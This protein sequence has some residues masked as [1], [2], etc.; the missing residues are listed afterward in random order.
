MTVSSRVCL[1]V[2]GDASCRFAG[3]RR[4]KVDSRQD[5]CPLIAGRSNTWTC[6]STSSATW[7]R[8]GLS[9]HSVLLSL[10]MFVGSLSVVS[11]ARSSWTLF[12]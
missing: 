1:A 7:F 2:D 5:T 11:W 12:H 4:K 6:E 3:F 10:S 9:V 8:F